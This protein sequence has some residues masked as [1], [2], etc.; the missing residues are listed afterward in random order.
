VTAVMPRQRRVTTV[1]RQFTFQIFHFFFIEKEPLH[2]DG[3]SVN[4]SEAA[5]VDELA[6]KSGGAVGRAVHL[7]DRWEAPL[8]GGTS[9]LVYFLMARCACQ[10]GRAA[11]RA[12][13]H[14]RFIVRLACRPALSQ[15]GIDDLLELV[16]ILLPRHLSVGH[17][18][19]SCRRKHSAHQRCEAAQLNCNRSAQAPAPL[20]LQVCRP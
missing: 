12:R 10:R 6:R 14:L 20:S 8:R 15:H 4:L 19:H 16:R 9:R 2:P 5:I 11:A 7:G 3:K 13:A 1:M 18:T 17:G